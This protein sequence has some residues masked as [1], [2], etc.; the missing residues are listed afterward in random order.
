LGHFTR[1]PFCALSCDLASRRLTRVR[2]RAQD[3]P[4]RGFWVGVMNV[5]DERIFHAAVRACGY[6]S[7]DEWSAA[8]KARLD[9][10]I[11]AG[12]RPQD[13]L[14]ECCCGCLSGAV[15]FMRYLKPSHYFGIDS[16][17]T[18]MEAALKQPEIHSLAISSDASL[19]VGL[20]MKHGLFE[21]VFADRALFKMPPD[22]AFDGLRGVARVL[23]V[24]GNLVLSLDKAP[25]DFRELADMT[26]FFVYERPQWRRI[27]ERASPS[28]TFDWYE[29]V[30]WREP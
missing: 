11:D 3:H 25:P 12:L 19:S 21:M 15:W 4:K 5:L 29:L 9:I 13:T 22:I 8:G 16:R 17:P 27:M 6:A 7:T 18:V 1:P 30:K 24:R 10:A 14:L 20:K 23:P 2:L 26:G 28:F